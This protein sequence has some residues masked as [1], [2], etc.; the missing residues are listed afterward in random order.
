MC[1]PSNF[2][3]SLNR[4]MYSYLVRFVYVYVCALAPPSDLPNT[5]TGY[6]RVSGID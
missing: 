4:S 6:A 5:R 3:I 1:L 2:V